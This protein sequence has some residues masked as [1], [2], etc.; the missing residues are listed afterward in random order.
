M[1]QMQ[2]TAGTRIAEPLCRARAPVIF[3]L[4]DYLLDEEILEE[5]LEKLE[6]ALR[7]S[8]DSAELGN[9]KM[10]NKF[11]DELEYLL[12]TNDISK[13][14]KGGYHAQWSIVAK[15]YSCL[16][17]ACG[18]RATSPKEKKPQDA[19]DAEVFGFVHEMLLEICSGATNIDKK[20]VKIGA[21]YN[22]ED[23]AKAAIKAGKAGRHRLFFAVGFATAIARERFSA[24]KQLELF[25]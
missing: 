12:K 19:F 9:F 24:Q 11:I 20:L 16:S 23:E 17:Q 22:R 8:R 5:R 6:I 3:S 15:G 25:G 18:S 2:R 13:N 7:R 1:I 10:L 4:E 14:L 21:R